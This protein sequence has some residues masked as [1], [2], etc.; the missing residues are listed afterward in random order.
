MNFFYFYFD[1]LAWFEEVC[2]TLKNEAGG[3]ALVLKKMKSLLKKRTKDEKQEVIKSSMAY[4]T[5][6]LHQM[7]Y[8]TCQQKRRPV[9][10]GGMEA[11][12]EV[13]VTQR[14]CNGDAQGK[15]TSVADPAGTIFVML[16]I[17][18]IFET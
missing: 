18:A 10:T 4:F 6:H 7:D 15:L 17:F 9:A 1:T 14:F 13:I 11:A 12:G 3:A 16:A 2:H 8:Y 5:K